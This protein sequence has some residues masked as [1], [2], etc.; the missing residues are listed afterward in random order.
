MTSDLIYLGITQDST[1][2]GIRERL[3]VDSAGAVALGRR[4]TNIVP[5]AWVLSTCERFEVYA[6][7]ATPIEPPVEPLVETLADAFRFSV[8][9]LRRHLQVRTGD[10]AARHVLRVA[11]G[12]ESRMLGEHQILGQVR[13]A[14][15]AALDAG[16]C[17]P[18]LAALGRSAI[19]TGRRIRHATPLGRHAASAASLAV[20]R[21]LAPNQPA[22]VQTV[23]LWGTGR[24]AADVARILRGRR[25]GQVYVTSRSAERAQ[26][27]A[28]RHH[29][30]PVAAADVAALLPRVHGLIACS[31]GSFIIDRGLLAA[32][33]ETLRIVDLGVPRNVDPDVAPLPGVR[34]AHL[35]DLHA[36]ADRPADAIAAAEAVVADEFTR[37]QAW[38]RGRCVAAEVAALVAQADRATPAQ[39][40]ALHAAILRLKRQ[41]AA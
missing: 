16:T 27:F 33:G 11:A 13:S 4:L 14:Y 37:L 8:A 39:R 3:R 25:V 26:A 21:V 20:Q 41:V 24:L 5:Q 38:Q 28:Q 22:P 9:A 35:E 23:L 36:F 15:L 1:P 19:R 34:F 31:T 12:L 40:R 17:G 32:R 10:A 29:A 6:V 7:G 18:L 30:T 2:L